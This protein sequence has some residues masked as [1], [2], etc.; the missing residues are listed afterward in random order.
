MVLVSVSG[1]RTRNHVLP[2]AERPHY[3]IR[4][5]KAAVDPNRAA[6]GHP[7]FDTSPTAAALRFI[8]R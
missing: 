7:A 1:Q 4:T 5:G 3:G 8:E 2:I 6:S